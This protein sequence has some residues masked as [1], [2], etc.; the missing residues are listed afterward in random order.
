MGKTTL[1]KQLEYFQVS[2][3]GIN[4]QM[5]DM[6]RMSDMLPAFADGRPVIPVAHGDNGEDT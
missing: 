5:I 6:S 3:F 4:N 1:D 2:Y